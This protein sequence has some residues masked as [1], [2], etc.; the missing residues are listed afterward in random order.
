MLVASVQA[1]P[2]MYRDFW[3]PLF[4]AQHL[5]YCLEPDSSEC[6]VPVA[7]QYCR[8][9]GYQHAKTQQIEPNVGLTHYLLGSKQCTGWR[10]NGFK[11]ITCEGELPKASNEQLLRKK[12]FV[13]PRIN[14]YRVAWCYRG[15]KACG[16]RAALA[17]CRLMGFSETT[18]FKPQQLVSTQALGDKAL[19][20]GQSCKGF[21]KITCKR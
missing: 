12:T 18:R 10:C 4:H 8:L 1:K 9:M 2:T 14:N 11:L 21:E 7:T 6:G 3:Y 20:F 15:E 13:F 16:S 17:F 19:C 5:D